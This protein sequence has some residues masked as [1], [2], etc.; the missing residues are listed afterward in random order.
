MTVETSYDL[1]F[2]AAH[3]VKTGGANPQVNIRFFNSAS[4]IVGDTGFQSF[5]SLGSAWTEVT[6]LGDGSTLW[7]NGAANEEWQ[8]FRIEQLAP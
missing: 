4:N 8:F 7:H 5:S 3:V 2:Y 1:S 6:Y